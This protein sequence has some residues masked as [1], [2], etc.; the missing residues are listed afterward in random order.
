MVKWII[1][2]LGMEDGGFLQ[3]E[4]RQL[5]GVMEVFQSWLRW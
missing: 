2:F 5:L 1:G 3:S 4:I